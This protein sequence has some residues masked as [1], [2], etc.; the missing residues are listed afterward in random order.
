MPILWII[1]IMMGM[2]VFLERLSMSNILNCAEYM[3]VRI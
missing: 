3:Q 1:I 2:I